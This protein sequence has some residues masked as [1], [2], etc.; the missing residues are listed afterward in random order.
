M[1]FPNNFVD[2]LK[3]AISDIPIAY[4]EGGFWF[5]Y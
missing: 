2:D 5:D 3:E 1:K 4:A